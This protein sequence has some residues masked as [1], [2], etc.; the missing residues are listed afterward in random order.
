MKKK[1]KTCKIVLSDCMSRRLTQN[2]PAGKF[3]RAPD[4]ECSGSRLFRLTFHDTWQRLW[5]R[6]MF[7]HYLFVTKWKWMLEKYT[8]LAIWEW[9]HLIR[10]QIRWRHAFEQPSIRSFPS[11]H[12]FSYGQPHVPFTLA[13]SLFLVRTRTYVDAE[14]GWRLGALTHAYLRIAAHRTISKRN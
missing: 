7:D 5:E 3:G 8:A 4:D 6:I 10:I 1:H 13:S 12:H 14:C 2:R 9:K 11:P